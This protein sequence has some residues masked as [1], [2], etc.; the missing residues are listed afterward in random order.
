MT[1]ATRTPLPQRRPLETFNLRHWNANFSV[2]IGRYP[3]GT[4][5]E[6]FINGEKCGTQLDVVARDSAVILSLA[7]QHGLRIGDLRHA[8]TRDENG[9]AS[10]PVGRL[11]DML[12]E[13][14][15]ALARAVGDLG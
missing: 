14:E 6:I 10:G 15:T 3:D 8:V 7:L 12:H 5:G 1:P 13:E 11:L 2:G 4:I 9:E